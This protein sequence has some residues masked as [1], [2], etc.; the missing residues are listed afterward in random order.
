MLHFSGAQYL[1]KSKIII[2]K[3]VNFLLILL[4]YKTLNLNI[5]LTFK[6]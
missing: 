4:L 3:R 1:N 6:T 5:I 2:D